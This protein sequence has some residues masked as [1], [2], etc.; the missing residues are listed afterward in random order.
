[1]HNNGL[2][3]MMVLFILGAVV[4][5]VIGTLVS[6]AQ[7]KAEEAR[8]AAL[9]ALATRRG[10]DF[11]PTMMEVSKG[12]WDS[13]F[14]SPRDSNTSRFLSA[15]EG[16]SPFG[17]GHSWSVK[18]LIRGKKGDLEWFA[19]DYL[20]KTTQSTGKTTT[21]VPHPTGVVAVRIPMALPA[22]TLSPESVFHKLGS[23]LGL[24]EITLESEEFNRMYFIRCED[25]KRAYDLLHPSMIEY[26]MSKP[27]R[28]W[29]LGGRFLV[30]TRS[31]YYEPDEI[32]ELFE[33]LQGFI[34]RIPAYVRE[35]LRI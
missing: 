14:S 11:Q 31:G 4:I 23:L 26:L 17:Q 3:E 12:F 28:A 7:K 34:D 2:V 21:T 35:D 27:R 18:D 15:F 20:Y 32:E 33:E 6:I 19:F 22:L 25:R 24:K 13:L 5:V 16:F 10:L 29:Q 1:M 9:F 30:M 8:Q